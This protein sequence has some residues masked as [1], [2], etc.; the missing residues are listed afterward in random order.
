MPEPYV[1]KE[2]DDGRSIVIDK[3]GDNPTRAWY[4]AG[5]GVDAARADTNP[6]KPER[7]KPHP[8]NAGLVVDAVAYRRMLLGTRCEAR[9][10]PSEFLDRPVE[11]GDDDEFFQI[12]PYYERVTRKLPI[13]EM[14]RKSFRDSQTPDAL[15]W[16]YVDDVAEFEYDRLAFTIEVNADIASTPQVDTMLNL[17]VGL[18]SELGKIHTIGGI[19]Y[20]FSIEDAERLSVD[21]YKFVYKWTNDPGI[22]NTLVYNAQAGPNWALIGGYG[23]GFTDTDYIIPPFSRFDTGPVIGSDGF[24][25]PSQPPEVVIS[26]I[27]L[28]N[29]NGHLS[30]PGIN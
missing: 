17:M 10:I 3:K 13:I 12:S 11:P 1:W 16:D 26:P 4:I 21:K 19:D 24:P 20:Q 7:G 27:A 18:R 29:P 2:L 30:L 14:V 15:V 23:Y 22:P 5:A 25:D 8:D 6:A 9:Y 28:T